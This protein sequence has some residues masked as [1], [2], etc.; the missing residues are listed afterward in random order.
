MAANHPSALSQPISEILARVRETLDAAV[1]G[2]N[3]PYKPSRLERA[4]QAIP[5]LCVYVLCI[6]LT[7]TLLATAA[8]WLIWFGSMVL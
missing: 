6:G 1:I 7:L 3:E 4:I 2:P 5:A 8:L